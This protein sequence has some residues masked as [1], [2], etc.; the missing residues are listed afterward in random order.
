M[1]YVYSTLTCDNAYVVYSQGGADLKVKTGQIVIKGGVGVA[2]QRL[3][4][5]LGIATQVT[6][7]ELALLE[8][9]QVF[10][11]HKENGFIV[12]QE[13][14]K[15]SDAEKVALDMTGR[16]ESSPVTPSDYISN[17]DEPES[18]KVKTNRKG[19]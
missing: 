17:K 3:V 11:L 19:K 9:N 5:P 16:D 1:P 12:V 6:S 14:G 7:E 15:E 4:T 10:K 13:N 8:K 18:I 2:N